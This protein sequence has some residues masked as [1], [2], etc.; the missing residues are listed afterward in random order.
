M[1]PTNIKTRLAKILKTIYADEP[2][3]GKVYDLTVEL[4]EFITVALLNHPKM[5]NEHL[6]TFY[7][8]EED[9][10]QGLPTDS[11][12]ILTYNFANAIVSEMFDAKAERERENQRRVDELIAEC[13]EGSANITKLH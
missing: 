13:E 4:V 8:L 2:Q 11:K 9:V 1:S 12:K 7:G 10:Q 3:K 5:T 6:A